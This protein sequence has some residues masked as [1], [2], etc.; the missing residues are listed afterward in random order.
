ML[1][2]LFLTAIGLLLVYLP[3]FVFLRDNF[4][5][6]MNTIFKFYYQAWLLLGL[7][8][9]YAIMMAI[10][11]AQ[12]VSLYGRAFAAL[13]L[14][15]IAVG[16]IYPVAAAY[17]K[18]QGF[19]STTPTFDATAYV[20]SESPAQLAAIAWVRANTAPDAVILEG[21]GA[22][23]RA[24]YSRISAATGRPTLLGWDGHESQ[25]RGAAYGSMAAGRAEALD[26][27]YRSG[28]PE[29]IVQALA[30]W[31]IDYV[32]VG[33]TERSQYGMTLLSDERL[34]QAMD[35]VFEQGDVRIYR[36]RGP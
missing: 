13:S 33:P 32:Y 4:G 20:T 27:I 15:L 9:S 19:A 8:S 1:F 5:T 22:S 21:K 26:L 14:V 36:R 35:L 7:A 24:N 11:G 6:R 30:T 28:E 34:A 25:W 31:G 16:L 12:P 17:S 18:T 29:Q 2:A 10:S 23:Y 3:E